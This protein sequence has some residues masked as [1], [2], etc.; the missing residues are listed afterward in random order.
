M[1]LTTEQNEIHGNNPLNMELDDCK[2][3]KKLTGKSGFQIILTH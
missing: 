1:N 2:F 3:L